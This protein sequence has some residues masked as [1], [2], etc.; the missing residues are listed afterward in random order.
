MRCCCAAGIVAAHFP[1]DPA[2]NGM[3][4]GEQIL[5]LSSMLHSV[6][7]TNKKQQPEQGQVQA[8]T[9]NTS[10]YVCILSRT[11]VQFEKQS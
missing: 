10:R 4:P 8:C 7:E 1:E 11:D 3:A 5:Q 9:P 6:E 2:A